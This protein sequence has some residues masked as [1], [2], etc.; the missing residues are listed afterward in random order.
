[1]NKE[2]IILDLDECLIHSSYERLATPHTEE[3]KPS[4]FN[5]FFGGG[6]Y[7]S[8][9]EYHVYIRPHLETFLDYVFSSFNVIVW[10]ASKREYSERICNMI[11][12][13]REY[14]LLCR[15]DCSK[16][17][18]FRDYHFVKDLS[19]LDIPLSGIIAVDDNKNCYELQPNNLYHIEPFYGFEHESGLLELIEFLKGN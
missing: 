16:P 15:E 4:D 2:T 7:Q 19:K 17:K 1:M 13:D 12:K 5:I 14:K 6:A 18:D 10:T 8:P 3:D 9:V 11:M